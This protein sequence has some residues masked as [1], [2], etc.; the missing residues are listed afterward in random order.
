MH[1]FSCYKITLG[2]MYFFRV[3]DFNGKLETLKQHLKTAANLDSRTPMEP[4][5]NHCFYDVFERFG[6]FVFR[7]HQKRSSKRLREVVI[8]QPMSTKS[9][10]RHFCSDTFSSQNTLPGNIFRLALRSCPGGLLSCPGNL[11]GPHGAT[12]CAPRGPKEIQKGRPECT[13]AF[14]E[15][16]GGSKKLPCGPIKLPGQLNVPPGQ[17]LRPPGGLRSCPGG[18]FSCPGNFIGPNGNF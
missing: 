11:I 8:Y 6:W 16:P 14:R 7:G 5:R 15:R 13:R 10:S 2:R 17:L 4:V 18:L 12:Y 9:C 1:V 3:V